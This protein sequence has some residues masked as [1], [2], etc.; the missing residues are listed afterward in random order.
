[1]GIRERL[2]G[3]EAIAY[4]IDKEARAMMD[5]AYHRAE[6]ILS[7]HLDELHQ[8]AARL[9]EKETIDATEFYRIMAG[10]QS[11]SLAMREAAKALL[12][13]EKQDAQ[14]APSASPADD[15]TEAQ[16]TTSTFEQPE[17]A[18]DEISL[19]LDTW[20]DNEDE[21]PDVHISFERQDK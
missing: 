3:N 19:P 17:E 20:T 15:T 5:T 7:A 6:S 11:E 21:H 8:V 9:M 12:S 16:Q 10:S 1:M 13:A 14:S 2:S 18:D 4:A